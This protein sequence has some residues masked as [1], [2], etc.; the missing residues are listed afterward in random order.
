MKAIKN[1]LA[2][3]VW[4]ILLIVLFI[5]S[6]SLFVIIRHFDKDTVHQSILSENNYPAIKIMVHNGCGFSG[7]AGNI[8]NYLS[9]KNI[10]V[11]GVGNTRKFI[12]DESVIVVKH[13]DDVD[14]K[15]LQRMT[16]IENVIYA[17]NNNYFV[18]FIIIAGK[19]YQQYFNLENK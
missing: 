3:S 19:D 6:V 8:R 4:L 12:Y 16:G 18:P 5:A 1:N 13:D 17:I 14:L 11:I 15:R 7:V 9:G 10:E 2:Q